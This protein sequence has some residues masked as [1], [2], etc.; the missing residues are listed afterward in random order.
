MEL[1]G[2]A[3]G[4]LM[5]LAA[6]PIVD[7]A[8][9]SEAVIRL[10]KK[11]GFDPLVLPQDV[12]HLYAYAL[13]DFC[14]GM[15]REA[16][17]Y[18]GDSIIKDAFIK[19]YGAG[20]WQHLR[21][22]AAEVWARG[23]E[24]GE[25]GRPDYNLPREMDRFIEVFEEMV[26][27][28]RT[29]V[30]VNIGHR[31]EAI[32]YA[33]EKGHQRV[34][35][36]PE[37]LGSPLDRLAQDMREWFKAVDYSIV[38]TLEV[39]DPDAFGWLVTVPSLHHRITVV[40][41]GVDGDL[42]AV[43]LSRLGELTDTH[44][45]DEGWAVSPSRIS[46]AA[47]TAAEESGNR[48]YAFTFD[49]LIDL[50]VD[51]DGYL[52]WLDAE[53]AR[54]E[55]DKHYVELSCH[56]DEVDPISGS[57]MAISWYPAR[58][59]GLTQ[60]VRS[61]L[62][63]P[64]KEHL[65]LLGEFGTGKTWFSLRF[66]WEQARLWRKAREEGRPRPRLPLVIPLRDYAKATTLD[67]LLSQFLFRRHNIFSRYEAFQ[68]LNRSGKLMII[69]D[70]FDEMAARIDRQ[71]MADNFWEL[72]SVIE[73]GSKVLLSCRTEHFPNADAGR[74]LLG[75]RVQA[76]MERLADRT[77]QFEI[78]E[79]E[80]FDDEQIRSVLQHRLTDAATVERVMTNPAIRD[81][82]RRPV[83]SELVLEALP[84][85][86]NDADVDMTHV[87]LY[88]VRTKMG[89]DIGTG[90][91]FTSMADKVYFLCEVSWEMLATDTLSM[92]YR[93][94]PDRVRACFG[95]A[96]QTERD[97]DHWQHDM[98][99]QTILVRNNFGDYTPAHKSLIEFFAAYKIAAQLGVLD[100]EFLQ[101]MRSEHD[102][103]P[104]GDYRWSEYFLQER[105]ESGRLPALGRFA[106]EKAEVLIPTFGSE[107]TSPVIL[108][109]VRDMMASCADRGDRL[110]EIARMSRHTEP[111]TSGRLGG[112]AVTLIGLSNLTLR[113]VDLSDCDLSGLNKPHPIVSSILDGAKLA[114][115]DL[116]GVS[117]VGRSCRDTDMTGAMLSGIGP[118]G[119]FDM[120]IEDLACLPTGDIAVLTSHSMKVWP[121]GHFRT[122][123][124]VDIPIPPL[125]RFRSMHILDRERILVTGSGGTSILNI[126]N[127]STAEISSGSRAML[128][129]WAGK[130][131][132][133]C[134]GSHSEPMSIFD[135]RTLS[136]I[137]TLPRPT[138]DRLDVGRTS[139]G[140]YCLD[141]SAA[142]LYTRDETASDWMKHGPLPIDERRST[143]FW[144]IGGVVIAS[145]DDVEE[146]Y[147]YV[148]GV[149]IV[150][151]DRLRK[152]VAAA[153]SAERQLT[154]VG[155]SQE[156]T[157]H[158]VDGERLWTVPTATRVAHLAMH[159]DG[160]TL[161]SVERSGEVARR[162]LA[163]GSFASRT[164]LNPDVKGAR[165]SRDCG[166]DPLVIES[167]EVA[168]AIIH[169]G[170]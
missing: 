12:V 54:Q 31:L 5:K 163:D 154:A 94:F 59:G 84:D 82:M 113:G 129:Q 63:D 39:T 65:S 67:A 24:T 145:S 142:V 26:A 105:D 49:T 62:D 168:G 66:A 3:L 47:R 141:A 75:A 80:P 79:V 160:E 15:P 7:R 126:E 158:S 91:T 41:Y 42:N 109:F 50:A 21:T 22:A 13:V 77:P 124:P 20:D 1:L 132:I 43:D 45:A 149:P 40:V 155:L 71:A 153:H 35:P 56:K 100:G 73:P 74:D 108:E 11:L 97:L 127:A 87:Y 90:R 61:W 104:V 144:H 27:R 98:R 33:I 2:T 70:G 164:S 8:Q 9:H 81:L 29:A 156:I 102:D 146:T 64:S 157:A 88:A 143:L 107:T 119:G 32:Q 162:S 52:D 37:H 159:P 128:I 115:A 139:S 93:D 86:G 125:Q 112:N 123:A 122:D 4:L 14:Y 89:R 103:E 131:A 76:S 53:V 133:L 170:R 150:V 25:F 169:S 46:P 140:V 78:V 58:D 106:P 148:G 51:F 96:V 34:D 137:T 118:L 6:Q 16:I 83:M 151:T 121:E 69:F 134:M 111:G 10:R 38:R 130:P 166:L 101:L 95:P 30:E 135:L 114:R 72:A 167:L 165:I 57:V 19:S 99:A 147:L 23:E 44:E 136:L 48:L 92:N 110:A 152:H 117:F 116:R 120:P 18:F 138:E 28:S 60:Y 68:Q 17:A 161:V 55:I 36:Q 85:I